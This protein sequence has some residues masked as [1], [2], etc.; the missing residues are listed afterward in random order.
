MLSVTSKSGKTGGNLASKN[1]PPPKKNTEYKLLFPRG[2][3]QPRVCGPLADR[4][5]N[6]A[7]ELLRVGVYRSP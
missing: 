4:F 5:D 1:T 7:A 3:A 2:D 6:D